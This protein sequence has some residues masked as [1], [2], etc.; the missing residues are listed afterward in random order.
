MNDAQ[1]LLSSAL[2]DIDRAHRV[3]LRHKARQITNRDIR[4]L[5]KSVA[6]S[7]FQSHRPGLARSGSSPELT[8]V[9]EVFRAILEMT[10]RASSR[11]IYLETLKR[12]TVQV[13]SLRSAFLVPATSPTS[14]AAPDF[15]PL[16]ADEAMRAILISRWQ[17]CQRC[18][19]ANA[20]LAATVMM[21]GLLEALF[22]A[23][24]NAMLDKTTLFKA[25]ATPLDPSTKKPLS[26]RAW[27]LRPYIDVSHELGWITRSGK[28]IAAVLRDYRNLVHPEK[29][30]SMAIS[31]N[32]HDSQ[33]FWEITKSLSRQLVAS[34]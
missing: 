12:A 13:R 4:D 14:D 23:R 29:Q 22:V 9:D 30:R 24:A 11:T 31:L 34:V 21:G 27:T 28:D 15:S 5:L 17:E 25:K 33:M 26:L 18:L 19:H 32:E 8:E 16:A 3:I 6:Y 1:E 10:D 2:R 20:H 7:W